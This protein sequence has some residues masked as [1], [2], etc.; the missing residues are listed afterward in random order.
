MF[1]IK[2]IL[3]DYD[4]INRIGNTYHKNIT[5]IINKP[6]TEEKKENISIEKA[7]CY[8]IGACLLFF[9]LTMIYTWI[10]QNI[11]INT[12]YFTYSIFPVFFLSIL[13]LVFIKNKKS[14]DKNVLSKRTI[15]LKC[16]NNINSFEITKRNIKKIIK[17]EKSLSKKE[18]SY[19]SF[20]DYN[21]SIIAAKK[22]KIK[23]ITTLPSSFILILVD[24]IENSTKKEININKKGIVDILEKMNTEDTEAILNLIEIKMKKIENKEDISNKMDEIL[25]ISKEEKSKKVFIKNI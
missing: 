1:K 24:T 6:T 14:I 2:D 5:K 16:I 13:G 25:D 15:T 12:P 19:L 3:K 7:C 23:N 17:Y 18:K 8:F 21:K 11:N 10:M 9:L 4:I 22:L 20:F